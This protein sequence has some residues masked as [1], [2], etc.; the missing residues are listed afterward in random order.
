MAACSAFESMDQAIGNPDAGTGSELSD[1]LDRAVEA[2]D[3]PAATRL[4]AAIMTKLDTGRRQAGLAAGY[5]SAKPMM[6][7]LDRVLEAFAAMVVAKRDAALDVSGAVEPQAAFENA[8]GV[9][10]WRAMLEALPDIDRPAGAP[11]RQC[12]TVAVSL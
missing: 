2:K 9:E 3:G 10:A 4:A 11:V 6:T 8:G 1:E 7:Q 5:P 12:P